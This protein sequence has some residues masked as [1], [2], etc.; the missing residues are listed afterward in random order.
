MNAERWQQVKTIFHR[1]AEYDPAARAGFLRESCGDDA[2]LRSEVESLLA[3][4]QR[5]GSLLENPVLAAGA[6]A[7]RRPAESNRA[8]HC[9]NVTRSSPN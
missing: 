3:S 5:P 8:R 9:P 1:A 7:A 6:V 2:D 4:E